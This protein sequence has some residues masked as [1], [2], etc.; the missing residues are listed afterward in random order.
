VLALGWRN[1]GFGAWGYPYAFPFR[2]TIKMPI[3]L[4]NGCEFWKNLLQT[5]SGVA[6]VGAGYR[7][8][9]WLK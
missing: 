9:N 4:K 5:K 8:S 6:I 2:N 1:A 3:K 7:A